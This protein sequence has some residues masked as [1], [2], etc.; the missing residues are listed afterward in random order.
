LAPHL[1]SLQQAQQARL[2]HL[3]LSLQARSNQSLVRQ[4]LVNLAQ[5]NLFARKYFVLN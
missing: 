4:C 5:Q 3:G 1:G 2:A